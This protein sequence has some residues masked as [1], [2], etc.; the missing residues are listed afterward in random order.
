MKTSDELVIRLQ[1]CTHLPQFPTLFRSVGEKF[2][3]S[4]LCILK[5]R[6]LAF[7]R[8]KKS[9]HQTQLKTLMNENFRRFLFA[10]HQSFSFIITTNPILFIIREKKRKKKERKINIEK[11]DWFAINASLISS[12][13][14]E[15]YQKD[16]C[17]ER[18][19]FPISSLG[20]FILYSEIMVKGNN[21]NHKLATAYGL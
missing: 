4:R 7:S 5:S 1:T 20:K 3:L 14:R 10:P 13:T 6:V 2:A 9:L 21:S 17:F 18:S 15:F 11:L 16:E 8:K 12:Q 19:L